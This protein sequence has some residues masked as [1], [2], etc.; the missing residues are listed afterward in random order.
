V[1]ALTFDDGPEASGLNP[2]LDVLEKHGIKATFFY[3]APNLQPGANPAHKVRGCALHW[4][5][6]AV[7]LQGYD[8]N[9]A[10]AVEALHAGRST[11]SALRPQALCYQAQTVT[12]FQLCG[13]L[14][15]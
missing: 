7:I 2:V 8:L 1:L 4:L 11:A 14:L 6:Y 10:A 13:V 3:N 9:M 15:V 12:C 5:Q